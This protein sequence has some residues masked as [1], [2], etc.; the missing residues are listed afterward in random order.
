MKVIIEIPEKE[1]R[2]PERVLNYFYQKCLDIDFELEKF[3]VSI[4]GTDLKKAKNKEIKNG[5]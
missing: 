3:S 5:E 1:G 4:E 2:E